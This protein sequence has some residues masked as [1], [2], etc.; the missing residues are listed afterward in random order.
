VLE[1]VVKNCGSIAHVDVA[2]RDFMD[3]MK[4]QAKVSSFFT[5]VQLTVL[6]AFRL[7]NICIYINQ[8]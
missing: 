3:F 8:F 5:V 2:T 6:K 7:K 1:S 4:D